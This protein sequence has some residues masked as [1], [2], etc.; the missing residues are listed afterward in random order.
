MLGAQ[1]NVFRLARRAEG[2][3]TDVRKVDTVL[4]QGVAV[5]DHRDGVHEGRRAQQGRGID[6]LHG[7]RGQGRQHD[8]AE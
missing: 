1:R 3:N 6:V 4:C 2:S 5:R 8:R 7:A